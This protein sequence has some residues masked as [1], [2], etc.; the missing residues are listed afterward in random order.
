MSEG[1]TY[2]LD[3]EAEGEMIRLARQGR[4]IT[5]AVGLFPPN[6]NPLVLPSVQAADEPRGSYVLDIG[7]ATGE[8]ALELASKFRQFQVF[9][10]DISERMIAYASKQA[11]NQELA[12][13]TH[14]QV[15]NALH[16]LPFPDNYFDLIH[17]RV[18]VGFIPRDRWVDVFR[19]CWRILRPQGIL[20]STEGEAGIT[21]YEN[22]ATATINKWLVEAL[23]VSGL[24]FWDGV[25]SAHG[26][27]AMQPVFFQRV[28]YRNV[29]FFPWMAYNSYGSPQYQAWLDHLKITVQATE[30]L[31]CG[32]LHVPKEEFQAKLEESV[33]EA[34]LDRYQCYTTF[35]TLTGQKI[36]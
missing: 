6:V 17:I 11:E 18:A 23:W 12:A 2:L 9:G 25:G 22:P 3:P 34:R 1:N 19:E 7:C 8:W 27:H 24:G 26:I 13:T 29:E 21:T 15:A 31:I 33:M 20:I 35:L 10:I 28:G 4:L 5:Q 32:A 36:L 16:V 14:F 30:P